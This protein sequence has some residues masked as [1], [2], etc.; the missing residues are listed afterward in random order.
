M[1]SDALPPKKLQQLQKDTH[2]AEEAA[3][4][5][6]LDYENTVRN[7]EQ[8]HAAYHQKLGDLMDSLEQLDRKRLQTVKSLMQRY[9]VQQK[10]LAALIQ[11]EAQAMLDS[12]DN[13]NEEK[14]IQQFIGE[15]HSR[16]FPQAVDPCTP[17]KVSIGD[18]AKEAR[19]SK[20]FTS[21]PKL[22]GATGIKTSTPSNNTPSI[23]SPLS[24]TTSPTLSVGLS[25]PIVSPTTP[26]GD[27]KVRALYEYTATNGEELS[28]AEGETITVHEQNEDGWWVGSLSNG[29]RG[30]FPSNFVSE[31]AA[32][33]SAQAS[34]PASKD[35]AIA[36][37]DYTAQDEAELNMKEGDKLV[38]LQ[39]NDDGWWLAKSDRTGKQ[40]LIP[41]NFVQN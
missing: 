26:K 7:L 28:F 40:G 15:I 41:S 33:A 34:A 8:V 38:I 18:D 3:T 19:L 5:A 10:E 17:Y 4:R 37:Y 6:E 23:A 11:K 25:S 31:D 27:K 21:P 12:F 9:S 20:A 29:K 24:D 35:S 2:K 30:F 1:K 13:V 22:N 36:L 14:E 16:E 32:P 39:K